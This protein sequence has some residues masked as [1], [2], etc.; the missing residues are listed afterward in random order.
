MSLKLGTDSLVP[1]VG[2]THAMDTEASRLSRKPELVSEI[3]IDDLLETDSVGDL[4]LEG[5]SRKSVG[6][7]VKP[8]QG[9]LELAS[10]FGVGHD[11][12]LNHE[13][14]IFIVDEFDLKARGGRA[15]A[16]K[17]APPL[18]LRWRGIRGLKPRIC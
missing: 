1:L 16:L 6:G 17:N 10:G 5:N 7:V 3:A 14:H 15:K 12:N 13:F 18:P 4:L 11:L 8:F 9:I 2:F